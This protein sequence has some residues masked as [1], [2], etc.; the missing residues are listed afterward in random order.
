MD[1]CLKN[2]HVDKT[3]NNMSNSPEPTTAEPIYIGWE[4]LLERGKKD[5]L[6]SQ[7]LIDD[8]PD[9]A[10]Y[11]AQQALEKH[12]KAFLLRFDV[13][14]DPKKLGHFPMY[15]I[16]GTVKDIMKN[17]PI[18]KPLKEAGFLNLEDMINGGLKELKLIRNNQD[19]RIAWW[20]HSLGIPLNNEEEKLCDNPTRIFTQPQIQNMEVLIRTQLQQVK[21]NTQDTYIRLK[22]HIRDCI[23]NEESRTGTVL[24]EQELDDKT[25]DAVVNISN[26]DFRESKN[27]IKGL[28][29]TKLGSGYYDRDDGLVSF[30]LDTM[31]FATTRQNQ[32]RSPI[33]L[34][35]LFVCMSCVALIDNIIDV[36]PHEVIGRYTAVID[37]EKTSVLYSRHRRGL[38][39]LI[40]RITESC[41]TLESTAIFLG[42]LWGTADTP[43]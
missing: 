38:S 41:Q 9:E 43:K 30:V 42:T 18:P 24:T 8:D 36:F 25:N 14:T 11:K 12:I 10:A 27:Q 7:R 1:K 17:M 5:L 22:K 20:K 37:G 35:G 31:L 34:K 13:F 2:K 29:V 33:D 39:Q 40:N 23:E 3:C 6:L 21:N 4:D 19:V 32:Q 15:E 26:Y 28:L 16:I